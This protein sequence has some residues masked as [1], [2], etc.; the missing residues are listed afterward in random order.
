MQEIGCHGIPIL[1][2]NSNCSTGSAALFTARQ[3]IQGGAYEAVLVVGFEKMEKGGLSHHYLDRSHP[4]DAHMQ[5]LHQLYPDSKDAAQVQFKN[6]WTQ[7]CTTLFAYAAREEMAQL[8]VTESHLVQVTCK[9][10][11]H[12]V[13]NPNAV[14]QRELSVEEVQQGR[15]VVHPLNSTMCAPMADGAAAAVLCSAGFL[16]KHAGLRDQAVSIMGMGM[17]SDLALPSELALPSHSTTAGAAK[18]SSVARELCGKG[19]AA[20]AARTAYSQA[21]VAAS[22]VDVCEVHRQLYTTPSHSTTPHPHPPSPT[23]T[24]PRPPASPTL[25]HPRCTTAMLRL[26]SC[27]TSHLACAHP[28]AGPRSWRACSGNLIMPAVKCAC[29]TQPQQGRCV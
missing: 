2:T 7:D 21:G 19:M 29:S 1:S 15:M 12:S 10:H 25:P 16:Q 23:L 13:N 14:M 18:A 11:R 6:Q 4:E 5:T 9:N 27:S 24:Q 26:R 22:D 28:A 20:A 8:G 17:V 3:L